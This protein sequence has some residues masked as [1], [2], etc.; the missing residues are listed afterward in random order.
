MRRS[1]RRSWAHPRAESIAAPGDGS[2][3]GARSSSQGLARRRR[4]L[5]SRCFV[6]P[7]AK[8]SIPM[9]HPMCSRRWHPAISKETFMSDDFK[10]ISIRPRLLCTGVLLLGALPVLAQ[11]PAGQSEPQR[12]PPAQT[13]APAPTRPQPPPP[14]APTREQDAAAQQQREANARAQQQQDQQRE[15]NAR[16]QQQQEQQRIQNA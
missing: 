5:E 1:R 15:A 4:Q 16:A 12:P 2:A 9:Y 8:P 14:P 7:C 13:P 11:R 3:R 10:L 6:A